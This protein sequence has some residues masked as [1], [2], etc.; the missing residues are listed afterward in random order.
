MKVVWLVYYD[1][2]TLARDWKTL[3][4]ILLLPLT[5]VAITAYG[6]APVLEQNAYVEPFAVA[7]VDLD[8]KWETRT[9]IR[10]FERAP[11]M[12]DLVRVQRTDQ[13]AAMNLLRSDQVAAMIIIPGGFTERMAQGEN[14]PFTVVGNPRRP[15][16]A[17]IIRSMM[18]SGADLVTAAQSGVN[19]V[20]HYL[21]A[22]GAGA[23]TLDQAF[24]RS[25]QDFSLQS[26]GRTRVL[27]VAVVS[28]TAGATP[29]QYYSVALGVVFLLLS[30]TMALRSG[31][32][33]RLLRLR[34]HGATA[35]QV[36]WA[37]FL[38]LTLLQYV[39]MLVVYLP[40]AA[41]ARG[42]FQGHPLWAAAVLLAVAAA[43]AGLLVLIGSLAPNAATANLLALTAIAV[44]S[45]AGGSVLPPAYLPPALRALGWLSPNRWAIDGLIHTVF[46]FDAGVALSSIGGLAAMAATA[47]SLAA[48]RLNRR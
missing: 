3:A 23:D 6:V 33:G 9:L 24:A 40:L 21:G 45:L 2:K 8:P 14:I 47:V 11:A 26:L 29:F 19:T 43:G 12:A 18:Q 48:L 13:E 38:G 37:Q 5:L 16:Q 1:L 17:A 28:A 7:V 35:G 32:G 34:A 15:L 30:G 39:Q 46:R 4:L 31:E 36:A 41:L 22:A 25:V 10:H 44:L 20:M 27:E 42:W